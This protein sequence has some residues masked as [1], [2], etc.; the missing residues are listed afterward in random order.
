MKKI[1]NHILYLFSSFTLF[2]YSTVPM[3][4][5]KDNDASTA[6]VNA[7]NELTN[8]LYTVIGY[9]GSLIAIYSLGMIIFS[10]KSEGNYDAMGKHIM[11][12][13]IGVTL[14]GLKE[15]I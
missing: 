13:C 5:A 9:A 7:V 1:K 8:K 14:I 11:Q 6:A 2:Y 3:V 10:F 12:L 4:F 15:L